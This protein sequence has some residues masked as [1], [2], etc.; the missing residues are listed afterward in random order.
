MDH[1]VLMH[2]AEDD[3]GVAIVD[4]NPGA[5]VGIVTLEGQPAGQVQVVESIPLGHKIALRDLA[6]GKD[7]IKYGRTIG[8]A[9]QSIP[10]GGHV[11]T[12]NVKSV[13]WG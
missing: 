6:E 4:L 11:H 2:E 13:R 7:V 8:R 5:E 1:Q 10:R 3:V 12:H 9:V